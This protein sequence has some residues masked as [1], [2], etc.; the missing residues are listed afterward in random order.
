MP[1]VVIA[2]VVAVIFLMGYRYYG[3]YLAEQVYVLDDSRLTPAHT[4]MDGVDYVPTNKH[5]LFGH[6]FT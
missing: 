5:V 2:A 6:H 4:M 3:K 1:A